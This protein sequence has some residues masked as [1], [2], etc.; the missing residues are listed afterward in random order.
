M[1]GIM[2][3]AGTVFSAM[4]WYPSPYIGVLKFLIPTLLVLFFVGIKDDII[5]TAPMKKLLAQIIV[6]FIMVFV[7]EY[8]ITGLHGL[9][10]VDQ[11]PDWLSFA[12]SMFTYIVVINA[13][14]L[15]DGVDGLAG[16]VGLLAAVCLGVW[17]YFT[18]TYTLAVISF[19]LA[20]A[21]FAFLRFNFQPAKIFM[22][23]SGS[24]TIG[25]LLITL[26]IA[27]IEQDA[28]FYRFEIMKNISK[29]ILGMSILAYPLIDTLRIFAYRAYKGLPPFQ[30]DQ[31]HIHHRLIKYGFSHAQTVL[32]IIAFNIL[33]I[34]L[35]FLLSNLNAT[36]LF[37]ALFA[38]VILTII[39]LFSFKK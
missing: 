28:N 7:A 1:G 2:I 6:A 11:I 25:L 14:N 18:R 9:F 39:L 20:G 30:A 21:L 15:I 12:L 35:V 4:F 19:S 34:A 8:R 32:T 23:D 37:I 22:G 5:G 33:I 29:P 27:M 24:L 36:A 13:F 3:F 31:N 10:G 38:L 16:S 26:T 17:F